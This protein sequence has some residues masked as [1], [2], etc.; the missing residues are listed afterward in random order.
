MSPISGASIS[1]VL[2]DAHEGVKG[3]RTVLKEISVLLDM[4]NRAIEAQAADE[5]RVGLDTIAQRLESLE[6]DHFEWTLADIRAAR[7]L[8]GVRV[9]DLKPRQDD[10]A[11][12][13][14]DDEA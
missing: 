8:A 12:E 3:I 10:A 6:E 7:R 4:T 14:E 1:D 9:G 11:D 5:V 2:L 13:D